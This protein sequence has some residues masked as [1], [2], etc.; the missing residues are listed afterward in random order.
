MT[1][2]ITNKCNRRCDFCF[3]GEFK[4]GPEQS[5]SVADVD[6][7]CTFASLSRVYAPSVS[8]M[9][10]EP[11][12]HPQLLEIIDVI[13]R[14]NPTADIQILSNLLCDPNLLHALK[15]KHIGCL[16]NVGG[17]A[18]YSAKERELLENNLK[19]LREEEVFKGICL[20]VTITDPEQDFGFLYDI[21]RNDEPRSIGG[22]RI[23]I[24]SPGF[25]FANRFPHELSLGYGEKYFEIVKTVHR[26]R[27]VFAFANECTVN[28]CMMPKEIFG[29]L[30]PIV[31]NLGRCC[32]GNLD[33]FPDFS[34]HWCFA[35]EGVPE[36]RVANIFD[37]RDMNEVRR[38]LEAK[39]TA[40]EARLGTQ[41][42]TS[43]CD[44]IQCLGPCL[45]LKYFYKYVKEDA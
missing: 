35:F 36:M 40:M 29:E 42:D 2:V 24:A 27:P 1:L 32:G 37:H 44:N 18:G 19:L 20:A 26:I 10:G 28:M 8:I 34:T 41:C 31:N 15:P 43:E 25:G 45:A 12:L 6:R 5:M 17:F 39:A 13:R 23:G 11:T 30:A 22:L 16:A 38:A 3:E 21:I 7:I 4:D 9:G 14:A 33:I